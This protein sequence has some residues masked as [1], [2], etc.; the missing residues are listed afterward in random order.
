M[1]VPA[2]VAEDSD[3]LYQPLAQEPTRRL[4]ALLA[5]LSGGG[6]AV[7]GGGQH[8]GAIGDAEEQEVEVR[9]DK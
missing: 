7:V 8:T 4:R 3:P 1:L 5:W 6:G 2:P 9:Q